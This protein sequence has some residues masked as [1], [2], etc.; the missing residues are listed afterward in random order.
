MLLPVKYNYFRP[1]PAQFNR[2]VEDE[3]REGDGGGDIEMGDMGGS[4]E[5][6]IC[7]NTLDMSSSSDPS[8]ESASTGSSS[9]SLLQF[10][11]NALPSFLSANTNG[12]YSALR[13]QIDQSGSEE[14]NSQSL[15]AAQRYMVRKV[16]CNYHL[17]WFLW[18]L[19]TVLHRSLLATIFSTK[20]A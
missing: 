5:C 6:V 20:N 10:V 8:A 14:N 11:R 16:Y 4:R 17:Y 3:H 12:D 7:Y 1:I 13:P 18:L 15:P 2:F 19:N 9:F